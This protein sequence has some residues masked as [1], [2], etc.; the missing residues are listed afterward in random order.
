MKIKMSY[1]ELIETTII[2]QSKGYEGWKIWEFITDHKTSIPAEIFPGIFVSVEKESGIKKVFRFLAN[3]SQEIIIFDVLNVRDRF[4]I[5]D[6]KSEQHLGENISESCMIKTESVLPN[7]LQYPNNLGGGSCGGCPVVSYF[8]NIISTGQYE[9]ITD[10]DVVE[11]TKSIPYFIN[12]CK[13]SKCYGTYQSILND[14]YRKDLQENQMIQIDVK[15]GKYFP[16][17]GKHRVCA[18][19]R[20]DYSEKIPARVTYSSRRVDQQSYFPVLYAPTDRSLSEYYKCYEFYGLSRS[21]ALDYLSN[22]DKS[23]CKM[24]A[25]RQNMQ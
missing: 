16:Q 24:I 4:L 3:Q 13:S 7:I 20:Y 17:E 22:P 23:L 14:G 10:A 25:E 15:E 21:E 5:V 11:Q 19:K 8:R 12:L 18:M 1:D 2:F 9:I 6:S